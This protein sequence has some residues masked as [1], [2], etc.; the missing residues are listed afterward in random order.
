MTSLMLA[1]EI[2]KRPVVTLAGEVVAQVKDIVFDG[3]EGC[4]T[5]FTLNGCGL[6]S[7]PLGHALPWSGVTALG[8]HAVVIRDE[9]VFEQASVVTD[10][11]RAGGGDVLGARLLTD[12]GTDLGRVIDVVIGV[13]MSTQPSARVVGC[14]ITST[15][16]LGH[17]QR[18]VFVPLPATMAV[19]DELLL[20]PAAA[21]EFITEELLGFA[22]ALQGFRARLQE[23]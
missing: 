18:P 19:S 1:S 5:G 9:T 15:E 21:S 13:T 14:R 23:A 11:D 17:H 22:T 16:A 12:V 20:V 3:A 6:F 8:S 4:L 7:G 2:V 10:R